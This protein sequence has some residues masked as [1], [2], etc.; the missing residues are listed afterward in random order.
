MTTGGAT[1]APVP[2]R[3]PPPFLRPSLFVD[4]DHSAAETNAIQEFNLEGYGILRGTFV[5]PMVPLDRGFV[6]ADYPTKTIAESKDLAR[7]KSVGSRVGHAAVKPVCVLFSKNRP[8][9]EKKLAD[10]NAILRPLIEKGSIDEIMKR[11]G[12]R[13]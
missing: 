12:L 5:V 10:F 11:Y 3:F 6:E 4:P 8:H 9:H 13:T 7:R 2:F 1:V